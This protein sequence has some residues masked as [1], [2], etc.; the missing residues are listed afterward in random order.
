M[1]GPVLLVADKNNKIY[2]LSEFA[3][4]GMAG[5]KIFALSAK[6][7]IPLPA[8]A[9]LFFLPQRT[10][11]GLD[12]KSSEFRELEGYSPVAAFVPPGYTQLFTCAY[13]E[14]RGADILPLFSYAPLAWYKN[15]FYVPAI[16]VDQRKVHDLRGLNMA[17]LRRNIQAFKKT[18]NRVI[19][20]LRNCALSY[21][22]PNAVNFFLGRY[23]CPLPTSG[24]CNAQC[25]GCISFQPKNSCASSQ[26]RINFIPTPEEIAEIAL[27][28]IKNAADPIV[29]FGQGCEGEP[30]LA[31]EIICEAIK[32][33][34]S[35][36]QKGTIHMNTNA[37]LPQSL[38]KLFD[39]GLDSIRVSFNSLRQEFY[40]K[41]Y[42]PKGYMFGDV[43]KSV[44][45]AK[46]MG[47]FVSLNYLVMPGFTDEPEE[48]QALRK[49]IRKKNI[50]MIQWRNLNYDPRRYFQELGI[51]KSTEK[52]LGIKTVMEN[53]KKEFPH[54][55][56][57][58]FNV[59]IAK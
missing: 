45:L 29:S 46:K 39:R 53:I 43:L 13:K 19:F 10:P 21:K 52:L 12:L 14:R 17:Q 47:K 15:R 18:K 6:D 4:G 57:G 31:W 5:D 40:D 32:I 58:Y 1:K 9:K 59:P 7:L 35:K 27:I 38:N 26:E 36:T 8:E 23:E 3:A 55:R 25:L 30:L 20:H 41:Y 44:S 54:V 24:H 16:R 33:I 11:L 49:F 51:A 56:Y 42:R 22:C 48:W 37:S 34:R 50:D 2:D 28:H